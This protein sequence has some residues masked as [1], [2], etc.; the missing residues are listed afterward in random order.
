MAAEPEPAFVPEVPSFTLDLAAC[1]MGTVAACD[2]M[3]I[4]WEDARN[5]YETKTAAQVLEAI[6]GAC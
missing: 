1:D 6:S 2:V 5:H 4:L 3:E